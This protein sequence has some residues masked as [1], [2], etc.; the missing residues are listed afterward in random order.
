MI[1]KHYVCDLCDKEFGTGHAV[2]L[3]SIKVEMT[4]TKSE[5][6]IANKYAP[7]IEIAHACNECMARFHRMVREILRELTAPTAR[8]EG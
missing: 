6:S 2:N 7:V 3:G 1:R 5:S 8:G 4:V